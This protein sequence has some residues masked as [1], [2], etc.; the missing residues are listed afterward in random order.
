METYQDLCKK[1]NID[2]LCGLSLLIVE[3]EKNIRH[4][5]IILKRL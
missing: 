1:N 3:L 2:K 5:K 4:L